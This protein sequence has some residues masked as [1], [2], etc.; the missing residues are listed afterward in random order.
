MRFEYSDLV[1][2][3][4]IYIY[5]I[6]KLVKFN[7]VVVIWIFVIMIYILECINLYVWFLSW[8]FVVDFFM[9]CM[10]NIVGLEGF[11]V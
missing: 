4:F 11:Y 6:Y 7:F 8:I 1:L 2:K 3:W 10:I 9:K 5:Y